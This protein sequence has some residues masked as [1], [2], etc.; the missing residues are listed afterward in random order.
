MRY[1]ENN[2]YI[3]LLFVLH[4]LRR[5]LI[6]SSYLS[7]SSTPPLPHSSSFSFYS[8]YVS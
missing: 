1:K 3:F 6:T 2:R 4:I 7:L 5:E 8:R